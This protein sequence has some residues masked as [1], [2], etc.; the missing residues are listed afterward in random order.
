MLFE[1]DI[2]K[3]PLLVCVVENNDAFA[4]KMHNTSGLNIFN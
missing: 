4:Q 2:S 1:G 3:A